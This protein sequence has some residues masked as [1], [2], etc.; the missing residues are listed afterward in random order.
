MQ[1]RKFSREYK[2]EAVKLVRERGVSVAQ[3]ARDG[4]TEALRYFIAQKYVDAIGRL[5]ANPSGRTLVIPLETGA[6]AGG[7]TQAIEAMQ[8]RQ[9]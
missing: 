3:A 6:L 1:R 9:P 4:G 8:L 7:I 2:L 5:A